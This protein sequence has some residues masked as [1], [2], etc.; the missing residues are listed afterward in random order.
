MF[1]SRLPVSFYKEIAAMNEAHGIFIVQHRESG[2]IYV[3]KRVVSYNLSVYEELF[4]RQLPGIPHIYAMYEENHVLTVIEEYV[5]GDTLAEVLKILGKIPEPDVIQYTRSLCDI[6]IRLH[7]LHPPIIHRDIKPSNI[8]LTEDGRIILIDL[9]AA[10]FADA[11]KGQDTRLLGTVGFAA[12]E[13]YGFGSSSPQTDIYAVGKLMLTMLAVDDAPAITGR[14][15][16]VVQKCLRMEPKKRYQ[17]AAQLKSAL[18]RL[19]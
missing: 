5:S 17:S 3:K 10:K 7:A 18:G 12:P 6:L 19:R 16:S 8:I 2:K 9:N 4:K 15:R 14:L 11:S 13:Q 1:D